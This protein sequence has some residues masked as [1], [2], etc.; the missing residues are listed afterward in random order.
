MCVCTDVRERL[1]EREREGGKQVGREEEGENKEVIELK[2][3]L[4]FRYGE[5][6]THVCSWWECKLV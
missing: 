6:G 1:K 3:T 5:K 4:N 2:N